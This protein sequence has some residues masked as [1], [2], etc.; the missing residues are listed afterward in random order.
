MLSRAID[1]VLPNALLLGVVQEQR[2]QEP[3]KG[4]DQHDNPHSLQH[5]RHFYF[6]VPAALAATMPAVRVSISFFIK[7]AS[8]VK[9][10][11]ASGFCWPIC[12]V[13]MLTI[14]SEQLSLPR[15]G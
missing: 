12:A 3:H 5:V 13:R 10:G 15:R 14:E 9:T 6:R 8:N 1:V 4:K 2:N 11:I 7:P